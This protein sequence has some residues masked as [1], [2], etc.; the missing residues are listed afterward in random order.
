VRLPKQA[1]PAFFVLAPF[2]SIPF[3]NTIILLLG[4]NL[5]NCSAVEI[6]TI[7]DPIIAKSTL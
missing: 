1:K 7:P 5:R 3:S 4:C 2:G 6:P